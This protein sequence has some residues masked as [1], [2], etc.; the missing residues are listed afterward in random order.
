MFLDRYGILT[1]VSTRKE[2]GMKR[3]VMT[4]LAVLLAVTCSADVE[5]QKKAK[6]KA[7]ADKSPAVQK[8]GEATACPDAKLQCRDMDLYLLIG[9]SNMA[10]RGVLKKT[11]RV[12][13]DRVYKFG[14][15]GVWV[16]AVEPIHFDKRA[17]GAGLAASFARTM[18][19]RDPSVRIGLVPCAVGG[20]CIDTWVKGGVN[21]TK[22]VARTR[23]ALEGGVL[24]GILWH[25]GESD[26]VDPAR[27]AAWADKFAGIVA[28]LRAEFGDVPVVAGELGRYLDG[29]TRKSTDW[30]A[31]NSQ[32]HGLKGRI[33]SFAVVSSEGLTAKADK[34][35]LNTKSLR[36]FGERYASAMIELN[37]DK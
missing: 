37:K 17:A 2:Y 32:L 31:I 6:L 3:I 22:A 26:A 12:G 15:D 8:N 9:Q 10:G 18:A 7:A 5:V 27:T 33:P 29:Y 34:L 4:I 19:D 20:S 25:Q 13:T 23:K 11:N 30:R 14:K 35:H 1:G 24:K 36:M 28:A 16:E 21:Y